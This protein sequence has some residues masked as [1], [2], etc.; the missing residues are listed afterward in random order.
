MRMK[1]VRLASL[2]LGLCGFLASAA[3]HASYV[4]FVALSQGTLS[5]APSATTTVDGI[6]VTAS[7]T[8]PAGLFDFDNGFMVNGS[9]N[10]LTPNTGLSVTFSSP[11]NIL[12]LDFTD[13]LR[14]ENYTCSDAGCVVPADLQGSYSANG[15]QTA[16]TSPGASFTLSG[17]AS[18][19]TYF[20]LV[21]AQ[22][23]VSYGQSADVTTS[24]VVFNNV[25]PT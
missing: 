18:P 17:P 11:V 3:A 19:G 7:G 5:G 4:D 9:I 23:N 13:F 21:G 25:L 10:G 14:A 8:T 15:S 1:N 6:Q 20:S 24:Q 2:A 22:P 12:S 16:I